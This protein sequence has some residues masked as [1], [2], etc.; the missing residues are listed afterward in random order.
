MCFGVT[1]CLQWGRW[2]SCDYLDFFVKD[3]LV[4]ASESSI[5]LMLSLHNELRIWTKNIWLVFVLPWEILLTHGLYYRG[6]RG[7]MKNCNAFGTKWNISTR[8]EMA[9]HVILFVF[10]WE[11]VMFTCC[12]LEN[13]MHNLYFESS[14]FINPIE[15]TWVPH[16]WNPG[17]ATHDKY[18]IWIERG[19]HVCM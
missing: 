4:L 19:N 16:A 9:F 14:Q 8:Y 17:L 10:L 18:K 1:I 5:S 2:L 15:G 12:M 13:T 7:W 11:I 6:W 3:W